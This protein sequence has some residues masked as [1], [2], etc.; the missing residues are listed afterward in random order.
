MKLVKQNKNIGKQP[1]SARSF[2][3]DLLLLNGRNQ[4]PL[5]VSITYKR[6]ITAI[7]NFNLGL[8][9]TLSFVPTRTQ[10]SETFSVPHDQLLLIPEPTARSAVRGY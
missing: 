9:I 3:P 6:L 4:A 1:V 5:V 7:N 8:S 10:G 2:P